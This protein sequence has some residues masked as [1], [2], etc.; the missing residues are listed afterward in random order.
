M[1]EALLDR[2]GP[3]VRRMRRVRFFRIM[4]AVLLLIGVIGW[5]MRL[6]V[7]SG[8]VTGSALALSLLG[9]A[10]VSAVVVAIVCRMSFRNPRMVAKQIEA[11]FPTLDHRLLT[12]LSQQDDQLGL[13][14]TARGQGSPRSFPLQQLGGDDSAKPLAGKSTLRHRCGFVLRSRSWDRC[15]S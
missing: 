5:L 11:K 2:L 13:P 15:L 8:R 12:A 4:A 3:V 10:L 14:A 6:Q 7:E 1:N 9:L